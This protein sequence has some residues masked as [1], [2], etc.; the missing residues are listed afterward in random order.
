VHGAGE[1]EDSVILVTYPKAS[2]EPFSF[3]YNVTTIKL[4]YTVLQIHFQKMNTCELA[5]PRGFFLKR[6]VLVER[7]RPLP[8]SLCLCS[9]ESA[10]MS[11][12]R[13]RCS[14]DEALGGGDSPTELKQN[15]N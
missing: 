7:V 13:S 14:S 11:L 5:S 10:G 3:F 9:K 4:N 15:S 8:P 1:T 2:Y 12:S 6:G